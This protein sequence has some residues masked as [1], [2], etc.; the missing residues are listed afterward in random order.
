MGRITKRIIDRVVRSGNWMITRSDGGRCL[1]N[2]QWNPIG[3]WTVDHHWVNENTY[4][5]QGFCGNGPKTVNNYFIDLGL[6]K[7]GDVDFCEIDPRYVRYFNNDESEIVMCKRARVLLRN[8][9]PENLTL[10]GGLCL[11]YSNIRKLPKGLKLGGTL[12]L[13]YSK[14][15]EPPG[16]V[17]VGDVINIFKTPAKH[18][19]HPRKRVLRAWGIY[20]E[21]FWS[22]Y[23]KTKK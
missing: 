8:E 20:I 3:E 17:S 21:K 1:N 5:M 14:I 2:F 10:A 13:R 23:N 9:L 19:E 22:V 16:D 11:S 12:E 4:F 7:D 15:S 18:T 6:D